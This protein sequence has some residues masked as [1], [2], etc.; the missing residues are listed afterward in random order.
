MLVRLRRHLG[1]WLASG[2]YLLLILAGADIGTP[3]AWRWIAAGI[4]ALALL[5]WL[6]AW[7]R[8]RA[9]A[10]LPTSR[11]ATAAQGYVE[12]LGRG[13][14]EPDAP[15][16]APLK[17]GTCLWYRYRIQRKQGDS[18]VTDAQGES[19]NPFLITD[20]TGSCRVYPLG[21][22]VL[23]RQNQTWHEG[24]HRY[25]LARLDPGETI[26]VLGEFSTRNGATLALAE[27]ASVRDLLA[28]WKQ[29]MPGLLQ[30]FDLNG[31]GTLDLDEW[32]LARA[33]AR[34]EVRDAHAELRAQPASHSIGAPEDGRL[35]LIS[36]LPPER[37]ER[38]FRLWSLLHVAVFLAALASQAYLWPR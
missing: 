19:E 14:A 6:A 13:L 25:T 7:G 18:W 28:D 31:D 12:L 10:D 16:H 3:D 2:G 26:Y 30:R 4:A 32:E 37:I 5:A 17:G 34:R 38:R 22:E 21:G 36:S 35:Y 15:L 20:D 29:D 33:Q 24:D 11:I 1:Q 9:I 23:A 8:L 27:N